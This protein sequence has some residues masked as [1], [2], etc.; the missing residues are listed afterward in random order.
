MNKLQVGDLITHPTAND[1]SILQ[2]HSLEPFQVLS[3]FKG[4]AELCLSE[5]KIGHATDLIKTYVPLT[6]ERFIAY[7]AHRS[8]QD[9]QA[10]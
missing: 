6:P 2:V 9:A 7:C 1:Y 3:I 8:K 4:T 10:E 5:G